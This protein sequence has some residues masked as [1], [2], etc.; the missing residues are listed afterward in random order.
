MSKVIS[1]CARRGRPPRDPRERPAAGPERSSVTGFS[2]AASALATP[3]LDII[4]CKPPLTP[5]SLERPL[6][7]REV[8]ACPRSHE[9]VHAG[10][11][12]ALELAKL[13]EDLGARCHERARQLL[14]NDVRGPALVLGVEVREQEAD[15]HRLDAG[16]TKRARGHPDT[17]LVQR[18]QYVACRR[19][20][21]LS[22]D[23]AVTPLHERA[24]LPGNVLHDRVVLRP[25]MTSDVHDVSEALGR[26]EPALRPAVLEHGVRGHGGSMEDATDVGR[27]D[28]RL[29]TDLPQ[30][31]DERA[32][33]IV[34]C[35]T[36]LVDVHGAGLRVVEHEVR[37][38]AADV[39]AD[40]AHATNLH[41]TG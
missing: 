6:Q 9:G 27:L 18:L 38:R 15:G 36:N 20:D 25:L 17:V 35:R 5:S 31:V 21:P 4:T 1:G 29:A 41:R 34:R 33:G 23:H 10:G 30:P 12:E 14:A 40:D 37:E 26:H 16:L 24:R 13:G 39:D 11:R 2:A 28:S 19:S 3:P 8:T 7:A 22:N 32:T